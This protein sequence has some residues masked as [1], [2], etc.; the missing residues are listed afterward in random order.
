MSGSW[1]TSSSSSAA[2]PDGYVSASTDA[3]WQERLGGDGKALRQ[4]EQERGYWDEPVL[5]T[6]EY[7]FIREWEI[8]RWERQKMQQARRQQIAA[9]AAAGEDTLRPLSSSGFPIKA[10]PL[11]RPQKHSRHLCTCSG[12]RR[13]KQRCRRSRQR[14]DQRGQWNL[15]LWN[16]RASPSSRR[17]RSAICGRRHRCRSPCRFAWLARHQCSNSPQQPRC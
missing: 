13:M 1:Q 3:N 17:P 15:D 10:P 12:N 16:P 9:A 8:R 11:V 5:E 14:Q 4:R 6:E 7:R 2:Q